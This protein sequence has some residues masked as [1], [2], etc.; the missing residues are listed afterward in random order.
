M[1]YPHE[2]HQRS[3]WPVDSVMTRCGSLVVVI[4]VSFVHGADVFLHGGERRVVAAA[5]ADV[6]PPVLRGVHEPVPD[7]GCGVVKEC[8]W[9]AHDGF[10]DLVFQMVG[11]PVGVACDV[12][13]LADAHVSGGGAEP[14]RE[15]RWA[16]RGQYRRHEFGEPMRVDA[17]WLW[18][19]CDGHGLFL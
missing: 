6:D 18:L 17:W 5:R 9:V 3:P 11:E 7:G 14:D 13:A 16:Q 1:S 2:H 12:S 4:V 15:G 8:Q 10:S 19:V